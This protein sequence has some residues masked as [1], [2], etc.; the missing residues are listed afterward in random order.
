MKKILLFLTMFALSLNIQAQ[1]K[2]PNWSDAPSVVSATLGYT[3]LDFTTSSSLLDVGA[4]VSWKFMYAGVSAGFGK[5]DGVSKTGTNVKLGGAL[6]IPTKNKSWIIVNPYIILSS[7]DYKINDFTENDFAI[8]PGIKVSYVMP[9][10]FVVGAFFQQP[11]TTEDNG[12]D[13]MFTTFGISFG[14][15]F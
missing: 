14:R 12:I 3:S 10:K 6:P 5:K 7:L 4:D 2:T 15:S 13:T 11:F 8:G 9:S 1:V